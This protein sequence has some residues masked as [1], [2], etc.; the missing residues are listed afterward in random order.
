MEFQARWRSRDAASVQGMMMRQGLLLA[1]T[2]LAIG[3]V[4][5][6]ALT[7]LLES[8]LFEISPMD[9]LTY[10]VTPLVLISV[11]ALAAFAPARRATR[12]DP[13]TALRW[14]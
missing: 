5:A 6:L 8:Q 4:C 10:A 11:A 14:E 9:P 12:V 1:A 7:R 2:G 13:V 3:T